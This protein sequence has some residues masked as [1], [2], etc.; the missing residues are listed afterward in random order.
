MPRSESKSSASL[1]LGI[2]G[3]IFA[4]L[5]ALIGHI[6]SII[7]IVLGVKEYKKTEKMTGLILSIIGES[8]AIF[9][10]IIG[11]IVILFF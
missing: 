1:V 8:C 7:G 3:I 5:F 4:W 9:S 6:L 10:S 2:L 11:V